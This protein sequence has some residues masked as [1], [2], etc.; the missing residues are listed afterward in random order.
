[1]KRY[2]GRLW[3]KGR[4]FLMHEPWNIS[5]ETDMAQCNAVEFL[6]GV[7]AERLLQG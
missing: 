5:H 7:F 1:M 2:I 6:L 4:E 3:I